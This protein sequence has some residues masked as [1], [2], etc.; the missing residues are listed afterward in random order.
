VDAG[1]FGGPGATNV[2]DDDEAYG[3]PFGEARFDAAVEAAPYALSTGVLTGGGTGT[4]TLTFHVASYNFSPY[5]A[6]VITLE[7]DGVSPHGFDPR[8]GT[9]V[10]LGEIGQ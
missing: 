6:V 1:L 4:L 10:L 5:D 2:T 7:S 9:P 3:I 8:P